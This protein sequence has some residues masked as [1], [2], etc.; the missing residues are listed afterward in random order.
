MPADSTDNLHDIV[1]LEST[2]LH[3]PP[4]TQVWGEEVL[5]ILKMIST[6]KST[7]YIRTIEVQN[8]ETG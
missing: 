7:I 4:V 2:G 5:T 3:S 8:G 1:I 6:Q